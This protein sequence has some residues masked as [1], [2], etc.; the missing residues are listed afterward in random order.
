MQRIQRM[1]TKCS[2]RSRFFYWRV[3]FSDS[4]LKRIHSSQDN[5]KD[6]CRFYFANTKYYTTFEVYFT[7]VPCTVKSNQ[8]NGGLVQKLNYKN[9]LKCSPAK[10]YKDLW[11]YN[12]EHSNQF[13]FDNITTTFS[14]NAC[15][16][17][18]KAN[19]ERE[20]CQ[21]ISNSQEVHCNAT[22]LISICSEHI[23]VIKENSPR[24]AHLKLC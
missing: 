6:S 12:M 1:P 24:F 15:N 20:I 9:T 7:R 13:L 3:V 2:M 5:E 4:L 14:K 21:K 23:L 18:W 10:P 17:T 11:R 16:L 19:F 22:D 8:I